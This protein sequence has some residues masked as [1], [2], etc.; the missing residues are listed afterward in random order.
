VKESESR[1]GFLKKTGTGALVFIR[2]LNGDA[3]ASIEKK[4][5]K[6]TAQI[7]EQI[8]H[9]VVAALGETLIPSDQGD[10]GYRDL[11]KYHITKEVMKE[12]PLDNRQLEA[13][14]AA[15]RGLLGM[16]FC[17]LSEGLKERFLFQVIEG[18]DFEDP[19][20]LGVCRDVYELSRSR[21]FRL[22]YQNFPENK[23]LRNRDDVPI[24]KPGDTHQITNPNT[25]AVVTGWDIA[26]Y[27]GPMSW[28]E[29]EERRA[30]FKRIHW[31]EDDG[32]DCDLL[33]QD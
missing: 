31:H 25:K 29:E 7:Q 21:I 1:R 11:E 19:D 24:L 10:P 12:L 4:E 32:Y 13:F 23:V 15:A 14:D 9:D 3:L 33:D 22:Y 26:N 18:N 16:S 30:R 6:D 28:E 5:G 17:K 27:G 20:L 2:G 8:A